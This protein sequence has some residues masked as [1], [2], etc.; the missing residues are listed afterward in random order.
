MH[1]CIMNYHMMMVIEV[2]NLFC[3]RFFRI[4]IYCGLSTDLGSIWSFTKL[5]DK[6]IE[7]YPCTMK[8][9]LE[10]INTNVQCG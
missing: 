10:N 8:D 1:N 3:L 7:R 4:A 5:I 9:S 6:K 2:L